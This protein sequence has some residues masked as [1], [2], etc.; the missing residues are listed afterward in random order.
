MS[1]I[2][3]IAFDGSLE[4]LTQVGPVRAFRMRRDLG[5]ESV[6]DVLNYSPDELQA[7]WSIGEVR[8]R[9]IL[10]SAQGHMERAEE[11]QSEFTKDARVAL[12]VPQ[13]H[14][15]SH[16]TAESV[17]D[18]AG[19][20]E[21]EQLDV[22][23]EAFAEIGVDPVEDDVRIITHDM[24]PSIVDEWYDGVVLKSYDGGE[25]TTER[26]PIDTPWEKY[27][28]AVNWKAA[29]D[30]TKEMVQCANHVVIVCDGEYSDNVRE[31]CEEQS[32]LWDTFY[33]HRPEDPSVGLLD[34]DPETHDIDFDFRGFEVDDVETWRRSATKYTGVGAEH[35]ENHPPHIEDDESESQ[36]DPDGLNVEE[37]GEDH[38]HEERGVRPREGSELDFE[39]E[40]EREF[41][42]QEPAEVIDEDSRLDKNDLEDA[43][44]GGGK[45]DEYIDMSV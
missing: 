11:E 33:T 30:R 17:L 18:E 32:T 40:G 37:V 20:D 27:D 41:L 39:P 24:T 1:S 25:A 15:S 35:V 6:P 36:D 14:S 13:S 45:V 16:P 2:H 7:V 22:I 12:V 26:K 3:E 8:S 19:L 10:G 5:I 21:D 43:D 34:W 4:Q 28:D 38:S 9:Q 42:T 29:R 23:D 31:E 44:P